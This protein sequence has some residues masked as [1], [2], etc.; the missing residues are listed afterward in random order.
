MPISTISSDYYCAVGHPLLGPHP[1]P[2]LGCTLALGSGSGSKSGSSS[3][4]WFQLQ[5]WA[6]A[7]APGSGS[8]FQLWLLVLASGLAPAPTLGPGSGSS[9]GFYF[10]TQLAQSLIVPC[11]PL[12]GDTG[13]MPVVPL[14]FW[15]KCWKPMGA[16][17]YSTWLPV[18]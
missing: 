11:L 12:S 18:T 2:S 17:F 1:C 13:Y 10:S 9:S 14:S 16:C 8:G 3:G 15:Q 5:L 4:F 7:L 6:L